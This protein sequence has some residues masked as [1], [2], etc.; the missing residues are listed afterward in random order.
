MQIVQTKTLKY[1]NTDFSRIRL[2]IYDYD[3]N[4]EHYYESK[5]I[6][7]L[8]HILKTLDDEE[9]VATAAL[10]EKYLKLKQ[11]YSRY[12]ELNKPPPSS[13]NV[14]SRSRSFNQKKKQKKKK[15]SIFW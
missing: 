4:L 12:C 6:E 7:E 3:P 8:G 2:E 14:L 13:P 10:K 5:T 11:I 15:K 9:E 1:F